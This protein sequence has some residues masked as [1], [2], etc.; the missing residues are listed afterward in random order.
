M[1]GSLITLIISFVVFVVIAAYNTGK[2][3]FDR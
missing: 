3:V 2:S 1:A